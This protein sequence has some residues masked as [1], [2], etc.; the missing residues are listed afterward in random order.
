MLLC[1]S[2]SSQI[3]IS[4]I[5]YNPP[6]SGSDSLE[7]VEI[8]NSTADAI[9]LENY[10]FTE[11][12][13]Y[14]FPNVTI[15]SESYLVIAKNA[16][17][18]NN[19]FGVNAL[20]WTEGALSNSGEDIQ[21]VD[22]SGTVVDYVDYKPDGLWPSFDEGTNGQG[23]TI[24]LCNLDVN[25]NDGHNWEAADNDTGVSING[26]VFKGTPGAANTV[27]C[28]ESPPLPQLIITEIMFN[29][30]DGALD[31]IE[32][33]NAGSDTVFMNDV[34]YQTSFFTYTSLNG[35][36]APGAYFTVATD[37]SVLEGV[38]GNDVESL[39]NNQLADD[40]DLIQLTSISEGGA[41]IDSVRYDSSWLEEESGVVQS[42][43]LAD[44]TADN[45]FEANWCP[46]QG[47]FTFDGN[48]VRANPNLTNSCYVP[49]L[50]T[51]SLADASVVD[52]EGVMI[53]NGEYAKVEG[54]VYG[55]NLRPGGLQF[56]IINDDNTAGLHVFSS[57]DD[58]GYT[59][60]EGDRVE[61]TGTLNQFNGL[62][63]IGPDNVTIL[64][65]NNDLSEP[66]P[67]FAL[68]EETESRLLIFENASLVDP[69]AWTNDGPGF[70]VEFMNPNGTITVRIDN[71]TEMYDEPAPLG[72]YHVIGIGGQFD[73]DAP[74]L[75]DYQMLPRFPSD[76]IP[77]TNVE[78]I[79]TE[80]QVHIAPNPSSGLFN[81]SSDLD[82][83]AK[84]EL[85]R[86]DGK[87]DIVYIENAS[88]DIRSYSD[89]VYFLL[90]SSPDG[91]IIKKLIKN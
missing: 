10:A 1:H 87:K 49:D 59:V 62:A 77:V 51:T 75:D 46:M 69:S 54:I 19:Q 9:N 58:F 6:E 68:G 80:D 7:F 44:L 78:D 33:Y 47:D 13:E 4:E 21:L 31:F 53:M 22:D 35:V 84:A 72:T 30:P 12:F 11:G 60:N 91:V 70:N 3:V 25:N 89:G 56:T 79:L 28:N 15:A 42:V 61:I 39:I 8:Y 5:S 2:I 26:F 57:A 41:L 85:I 74:F 40:G 76:F 17:A 14:V 83:Y 82:L 27:M 36:V 65:D 48:I 18:I 52:D 34:S 64:T 24:E 32:V 29:S 81:V 73:G 88:I 63:Q 67:I 90:C 66:L 37:E 20:E 50:E 38:F 55:I 45:N 86:S 16:S 43:G 23:A 71:D